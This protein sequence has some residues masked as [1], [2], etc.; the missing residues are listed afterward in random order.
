MP[1]LT[2]ILPVR[3]GE[4]YIRTAIASVLNQTFQD[5]DL[6]V[7]EN[8]STDRTVE[9][10][11]TFQDARI[12]LFE[13]G[14]IN[15]HG[16]LKFAIENVSSTWIARMDADDL[17]FPTRLEQ[18][19]R[20]LQDHPEKVFV[21][22]YFAILTP[23]GRIFEEILD[24]KDREVTHETFS[25]KTRFFADPSII[26]NREK[27]KEVGG[28]DNEFRTKDGVILCFQ[29]LTKGDGW[30][31]AKPLHLWRMRQD[32]RSRTPDQ[33]L[34]SYLVR[35]KYAPQ[36]KHLWVPKKNTTNF[37]HPVASLEFMSGNPKSARKAA[38]LM[39]KQTGDTSKAK[40]IWLLSYLGNLGCL[41]YKWRNRHSF[42]HRPD[43]EDKFALLLE[44]EYR[45]EE[46]V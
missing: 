41:Y 44:K 6:W 39:R 38:L 12:K 36:Y 31:L 3:N 27:A 28:T 25:S 11:K 29:L 26:F 34:Q 17:M 4:A 42:R 22:T 33:P 46:M 23:F 43:W 9:I 15:V 14:P 18:Q 1:A 2:I 20:F 35:T 40:L 5:F 37:W 7:L 21:G 8:G 45:P 19:M 32:S 13:L 10:V 16:A 24:I 30:E